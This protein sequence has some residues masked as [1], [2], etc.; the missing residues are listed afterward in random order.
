VMH[1]SA[2][3][4]LH[5]HCFARMPPSHCLP[6]PPSPPT[7]LAACSHTSHALP[8]PTGAAAGVRRGDG[9]HS[10]AGG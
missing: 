3:G 2:S 4:S 6:C 7:T 1:G 8:P 5:R 10:D 9:G